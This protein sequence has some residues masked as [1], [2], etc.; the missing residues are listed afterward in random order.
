LRFNYLQCITT[1][2]NDENVVL[3]SLIR[4]EVRWA[5]FSLSNDIDPVFVV[6]DGGNIGVG[7]DDKY[8]I[9]QRKKSQSQ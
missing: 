1:A 3:Y 2:I 9:Q 7:V 6:D 8:S 5:A 4:D